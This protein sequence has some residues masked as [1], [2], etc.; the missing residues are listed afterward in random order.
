MPD[1]QAVR[2]SMLPAEVV[3]HGLFDL[4][5]VLVVARRE[6]ADVR[7][8]DLLVV[9]DGRTPVDTEPAIAVFDQNAHARVGGEV[10]VL[11][12]PLRAVDDDV[13]AIEEVPHHREVRRAVGV[14]RSDHGETLFF[15]ERPLGRRELRRH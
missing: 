5:L 10:P 14:L 12:P 6:A 3:L 13:V 8:R 7:L 9:L 15:E 4:A 11:D 1:G 2:D